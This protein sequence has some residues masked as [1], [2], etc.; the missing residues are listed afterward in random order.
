M[1]N[2]V[3]LKVAHDIAAKVVAKFGDVYLPIFERLHNELQTIEANYNLK[4]L[5]IQISEKDNTV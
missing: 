4:S 3:K 5:A 2:S 1:L